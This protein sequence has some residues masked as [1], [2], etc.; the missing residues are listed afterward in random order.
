MDTIFSRIEIDTLLLPQYCI[1]FGYTFKIT[2]EHKEKIINILF[3][4]KK[5]GGCYFVVNSALALAIAGDTSGLV[6]DVGSKRTVV[7]AVYEMNVPETQIRT[8]QTPIID[9]QQ[10][11]WSTEAYNEQVFE[12]ILQLLKEAKKISDG[13]DSVLILNTIVVS[14]GDVEE[15]ILRDLIEFLNQKYAPLSKKCSSSESNDES[16]SVNNV[17]FPNDVVQVKATKELLSQ[18]TFGGGSLIASLSSFQNSLITPENYPKKGLSTQMYINGEIA[19]IE[20]VI[21]N[22]QRLNL[23]EAKKYLEGK[24]EIQDNVSKLFPSPNKSSN[25]NNGSYRDL[26][27]FQKPKWVPDD[28]TN[29]CMNCGALFTMMRRRHQ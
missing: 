21:T 23:R 16:N 26:T 9:L 3:N 28:E 5:I 22:L 29:S 20:S 19:P 18:G 14:R 10:T 24:G 2:S 15:E 8:L 1:V 13:W 6:I 11:T 12:C 27:T 7:S 4:E 25:S 17:M